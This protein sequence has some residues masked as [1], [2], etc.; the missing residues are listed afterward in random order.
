MVLLT[1]GIPAKFRMLSIKFLLF[2]SISIEPKFIL[3]YILPILDE[4][5]ISFPVK[6]LVKL[7]AVTS[8]GV[9]TSFIFS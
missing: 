4:S 2:Q 7:E 6:G 1:T 3:P 8:N 5:G 9:T